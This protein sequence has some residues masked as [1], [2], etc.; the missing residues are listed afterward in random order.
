MGPQPLTGG[1]VRVH[2]A[3]TGRVKE[4]AGDRRGQRATLHLV[5]GLW[6]WDWHPAP[7]QCWPGLC[8]SSEAMWGLECEL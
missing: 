8:E 5:F 3:G 1:Q 4:V 2:W 6:G 7:A